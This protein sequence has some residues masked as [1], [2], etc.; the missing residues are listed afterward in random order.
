MRVL[1]VDDHPLFVDGLKALLGT[2]GF[3][4]VGTAA[5]GLEALEKARALKPDVVLM[6]IH[7]PRCDGLAATRA[8]KAEMPE[9]QVVMLTMS[10]DEESLFDA[11]KCGAGGYLL[12]T[13][14]GAELVSLLESLSRGEAPLAPGLAARIL[15]EFARKPTPGPPGPG[16]PI[17]D[18]VRTL[19]P[20]QSEVL[21][22]VGQGL[23]YKEVGAQLHLSE[24]TIK[25]H[26]G[27]IVQHLHVTSRAEAVALARRRTP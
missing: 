18:D 2:R 8:I 25:Y 26:M 16:G 22:L 19:T 27:E 10:S 13:L 20:R 14:P 17:S 24:R 6:D 12:K 15:K 21:A 7:M 5:D 23:T 11:I 4:V 1:L 3:D 9:V